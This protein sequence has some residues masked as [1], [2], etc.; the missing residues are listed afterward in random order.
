MKKKDSSSTQDKGLSQ[1]WECGAWISLGPD[2]GMY[3]RD[4]WR[5]T[6][7]MVQEEGGSQRESLEARGQTEQAGAVHV[8]FNKDTD[9]MPSK[10]EPE[11]PYSHN[12]PR[13]TFLSISFDI[14]SLRCS[15]SPLSCFQPSHIGLFYPYRWYSF[16]FTISACINANTKDTF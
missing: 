5:G 4:A 10:P 14:L 16:L 8:I 12:T 15:H 13:V 3:W 9:V 11:P 7:S 1:L 2:P 6:P